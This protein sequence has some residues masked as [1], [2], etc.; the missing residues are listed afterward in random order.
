MRKAGK[1]QVTVW[2]TEQQA[3]A[4]KNLVADVPSMSAAQQAALA[5]LAAREQALA[6]R[7][8]DS[9]VKEGCLQD[10]ERRLERER[11]ALKRRHDEIERQE[12]ALKAAGK[13]G[14]SSSKGIVS[15]PDRVKKIVERLAFYDQGGEREWMGDYVTLVK[16]WATEAKSTFTKVVKVVSV[17]KGVSYLESGKTKRAAVRFPSLVSEDEDRVLTQAMTILDRVEHDI[18]AAA[19]EAARINEQRE[20]DTKRRLQEAGHAYQN[21]FGTL[22]LDDQ[23]RLIAMPHRRTNHGFGQFADLLDAMNKGN[24]PRWRTLADLVDKARKERRNQIVNQI[25]AEIKNSNRDAD[26]IAKE[27]LGK[28]FEMKSS[29]DAEWNDLPRRINTALVAEKLQTVNE[30]K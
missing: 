19:R 10:M 28:F 15:F 7:E 3:E 21:T 25:A 8:H 30:K 14:K 6:Q 5:D 20:A 29:I 2:A 22:S 17:V 27:A 1:N 11:R 16:A 24:H 23:I 13:P 12:Q 18:R 9:W 4:I 26:Q